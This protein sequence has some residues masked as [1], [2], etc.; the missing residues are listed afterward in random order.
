MANALSSQKE[1]AFLVVEK[2][3]RR[4]SLEE[5]MRV[6]ADKEDEYKYEWNAGII[7]KTKRINQ[8]Q[9]IIQAVLFRTFATTKVFKEGGL[10]TAETDM[11]TSS[12]QLR[13]PDLAIYTKA[14]LDKMKVGEYQIAK[15]TAEVISENDNIN[16]VQSKLQEY[17]D[18]GV[19]VV[20]QIFPNF[21]HVYVYT[22]VNQV[23]ICSGDMICSTKSAF[24]DFEIKAKLIF[25]QLGL[26]IFSR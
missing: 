9:A 21:K 23:Q 25:E 2:E 3:S 5:F 4:T 19:E 15:W 12:E 7:E 14:Q 13:R 18:A 1:R 26:S 10:L 11:H 24:P 17:F 6:Y 20:W 22:A 16:H 8:Q